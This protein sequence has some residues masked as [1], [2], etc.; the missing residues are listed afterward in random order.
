LRR[1]LFGDRKA[2]HVDAFGDRRL[3]VEGVILVLDGDDVVVAD[4]TQ[5]L[6]DVQPSAPGLTVA[7]RYEIPGAAGHWN[8]VSRVERPVDPRLRLDPRVLAV[9]VIDMLC[10]ER[11]DGRDRIASHPDEMRRVEIGADRRPQGLAQ[12]QVAVG[13][14]DALTAVIL[15]AQANSLCLRERDKL[16]PEWDHAFCPLPFEHVHGFE[17]PGGGNPVRRPFLRSA[18]GQPGHHDYAADAELRCERDGVTR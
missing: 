3:S 5:R 15:H 9:H 8:D 1:S 18:S 2:Q 10:A 11:A 16:L 14:I 7:E 6:Q 12:T 17:R 4:L 13:I